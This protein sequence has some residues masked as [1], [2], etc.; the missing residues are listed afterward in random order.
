ML[1][2]GKESRVSSAEHQDGILKLQRDAEVSRYPAIFRA[3][4]ERVGRR[5]GGREEGRKRKKWK[6]KKNKTESS[7][8][9]NSYREEEV[10]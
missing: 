9:G 5:K 10:V 4:R 8:V 6:R 2:L 1:V 7:Q 3:E